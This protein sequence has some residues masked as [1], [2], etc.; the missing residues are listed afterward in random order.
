M[1]SRA[2]VWDSAETSVAKIGSM[3]GKTVMGI[4]I[5]RL[6]MWVILL[7]STLCIRVNSVC[8]EELSTEDRDSLRKAVLSAS[9]ANASGAYKAFFAGLNEM[10]LRG[11]LRDSD[12]GIA[13]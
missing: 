7:C 10:Q 4:R 9:T 12:S 11:I 5:G 2:F 3:R 8:G 1:I 6:I 13:L